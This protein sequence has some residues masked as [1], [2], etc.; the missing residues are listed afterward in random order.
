MNLRRICC[1]ML[2]M[3]MVTIS[4]GAARAAF[5][6]TDGTAY[7]TAS[8]VLMDLDIMY[9]TEDGMFAPEDNITRAE[10]TVILIRALGLDDITIP[11]KAEAEASV[12]EDVPLDYWCVEDINLAYTLGL[13]NGKSA[14]T[15]EP[16]APVTA[17][18]AIKLLVSALGYGELAMQ[19]GGYPT[20]YTVIAQELGLLKGL[21]SGLG[22]PVTRGEV[23][24]M[25]YEA[26][27]VEL[28]EKMGITA[29]GDL[30]LS[31]GGGKTLAESSLDLLQGY[32]QVTANDVTSL[33]GVPQAPDGYVMIDG[34]QYQTGDTKAAELLGYHVE[35]YYRD[36]DGILT[37]VSVVADGTQTALD[38]TYDANRYWYE[39]G[40]YYYSV[41]DGSVQR[42]AKISSA[43]DI[44]Y[45]GRAAFDC[46]ASEMAPRSGSVRLIASSETGA[47]DVVI[48]ED[49]K[50]LVFA[51]Y[52]E[53]GTFYGLGQNK[54]VLQ[55]V[56]SWTL[57]TVNGVAVAPS[58]L[59]Y[60]DVLT[61]A[62]SKDGEYAH[63]IWNEEIFDG[64][65][66]EM[67]LKSTE[68]YVVINGTQYPLA[69]D[70]YAEP[71]DTLEVGAAGSFSADCFGNIAYYVGSDGAFDWAYMV[72]CK[73][74]SGFESNLSFK[75]FTA[76]GE[77]VVLENADSFYVDEQ[78]I[79]DFTTV[80]ALLSAAGDGT[81][82]QVVRYR[83]N[84]DGKLREIDTAAE[85]GLLNRIA[86]QQSWMY[87]QASRSF[88][89]K[90][91]MADS[92]VIFAV[93][94]DKSEDSLY[95]ALRT[96][97]LLAGKRY[98]MDVYG[99]SSNI[100]ADAIVI[101]EADATLVDDRTS[102]FAVVT[103]ITQTLDEEGEEVQK[104]YLLSAD[105]QESTAYLD[106]PDLL[107]STDPFAVGDAVRLGLNSKGYITSVDKF[108]S[109]ST[110]SGKDTGTYSTK[111]RV[112]SG[113]VYKMTG[114]IMEVALANQT[115]YGPIVPP[116]FS[117]PDETKTIEVYP[118]DK[119]D[120]LI[121]DRSAKEGSNIYAGTYLDI[122]DYE[123][124]GQGD[125]VV[126]QTRDGD[127]IGMLLIKQ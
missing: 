34:V 35:F 65:V 84:S 126:I 14:T 106:N 53:P 110:N 127:P 105:G 114:N 24:L 86:T 109:S 116:D 68:P 70:W 29:D 51:G 100:V 33:T 27:S 119:F 74:I 81:I 99:T 121:Y 41:N 112:G 36:E 107:D 61:A 88:E 25:V 46:T 91:M 44:I 50:N 66:T 63:I 95:A 20:G 15:F 37:L 90:V 73:N 101:N 47:Y 75:L 52:D 3:I 113:F 94:A 7:E 108:F 60:G 89:A 98:T 57:E 64:T 79:T 71:G 87:R 49:Y 111:F 123:T 124:T 42:R 40:T 96:S 21:D 54:I 31:S 102:V 28:L 117:N 12:F 4:A 85:G 122:R 115:V 17:A 18:E 62:V 43:A 120:I 125:Q 10:V 58:E 69:P 22:E 32:G 6:D 82:H 59:S 67:N 103:S 118:A 48:I 83:V 104:L 23:A 97:S 30:H 13:V 5:P 8:Q 45:N 9:G 55:D 26:L 93:P 56:D 2:V 1:V 19:R 72:D 38:L 11:V 76:Q 78:R 16:D 80:P 39:D 77:M 92:M